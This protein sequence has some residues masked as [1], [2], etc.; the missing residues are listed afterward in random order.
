MH[1]PNVLVLSVQ[2]AYNR[3]SMKEASG[4]V[5]FAVIREEVQHIFLEIKRG[6]HPD[7]PHKVWG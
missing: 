1:L 2:A 5:I 3:E 6:I 4:I 7:Q